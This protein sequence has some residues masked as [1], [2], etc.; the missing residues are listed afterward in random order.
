MDVVDPAHRPVTV[1]RDGHQ[2]EDGGGTAEDVQGGPH[3]A[4]RTE[5]RNQRVLTCSQ[6]K[7]KRF[8]DISIGVNLHCFNSN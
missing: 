2:V 5:P 8:R 6:T 1:E 4:E 3:V 7:V